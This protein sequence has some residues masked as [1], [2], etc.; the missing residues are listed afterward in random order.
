M[1]SAQGEHKIMAT[2]FSPHFNKI[3]AALAAAVL[4]AGMLPAIASAQALPEGEIQGTVAS[5]NDTFNISVDDNRGSMDNIELHQ[6]TI[7]NPTGLTL[8]PGMAVT[9][10]GYGDGN[11]FDANEID[12][13]YSYGGAAP[14][15]AYYGPGFWYPGFAYGYGPSF[16]LGLGN[17]PVVVREPWHGHWYDQRPI[18]RAAYRPPVFVRPN[19]AMMRPPAPQTAFHPAMPEARPLNVPQERPQFAPQARPQYVPPAAP[20]ARPQY[21]PQ[22][23]PQYVPQAAPQARPQFVPQARPQFVP[24]AA[25][26]AR[27]QFAAQARPL[28][29]PAARVPMPTARDATP[30]ANQPGQGHNRRG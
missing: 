6:G 25:P 10:L 8:E 1:K 11:Q 5:I 12:T 30:D 4:G 27:P 24:Q 22:A 19:A 21:V 18:A 3:T 13:P 15:P 7:I 23:R 20:Q 16:S 2:H 14:T 9:I 17:G 29:A 28:L 26:Q